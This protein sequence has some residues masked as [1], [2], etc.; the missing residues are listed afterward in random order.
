[1]ETATDNLTAHLKQIASNNRK[2]AQDLQHGYQ[3]GLKRATQ[4]VSA[5]TPL[6]ALTKKVSVLHRQ[7]FR[8]DGRKDALQFALEKQANLSDL[9]VEIERVEEVISRGLVRDPHGSMSPNA[10][11][12]L[13]RDGY[14]SGL[15]EAIEIILET[16]EE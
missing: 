2:N 4:L 15:R 6:E 7:A 8:S 3:S 16:R 9:Q 12:R 14:I 10:S 13:Y 5:A 11:P 1:M